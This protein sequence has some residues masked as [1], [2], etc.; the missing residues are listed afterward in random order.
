M[1]Q[2]REDLNVTVGPLLI[3]CLVTAVG[4]GITTMQSYMYWSRFPRDPKYIKAVVAL[5]F[6]LDTA[7]V[8]LSW[9]MIYYY[10]VTKYADYAALQNSVWSFNV[11]I[12][13]TT[14]ITMIVHCFFA[15]RVYI[16]GNKNW[17]LASIIVSLSTVRM[18]LGWYTAIRIFSLENLA[19]LPVLLTPHVGSA[20]GA[21]TL[22]DCIITGSLVYY[23][24]KHKTGFR[25]T[26][27]AVDRVVS[28]TVNNGFLTSVVGLT[29][30]VT[31]STMTT[32]M[33]FCGVHLLLSKLYANSLLGTLNFRKAHAGRG[34]QDEP[35]TA[36]T[37]GLAGLQVPGFSLPHFLDG[38]N[39][40]SMLESQD[41]PGA[42]SEIRI[43]GAAR[44]STGAAAVEIASTDASLARTPSASSKVESSGLETEKEV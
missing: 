33:V 6:I 26:D 37:L 29:V 14:I 39:S 43:L 12:V 5:L 9:H 19:L 31:F 25:A 23:L 24:R 18:V 7:H 35:T 42:M 3:G 41:A 11:T 36:G 21:G 2:K 40:D 8:I 1:V 10:L 17:F 44:L 27:N 20:L 38:P 32:N 28:W 16:L 15:R 4:Y 13:V 30:V 22:A 34:M